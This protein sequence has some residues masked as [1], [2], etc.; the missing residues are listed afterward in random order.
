MPVV[1]GAPVKNREIAVGYPSTAG[2][3][4]RYCTSRGLSLVSEEGGMGE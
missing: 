3:H 2:R 4:P 1:L